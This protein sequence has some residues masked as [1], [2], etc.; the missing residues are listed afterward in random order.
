MTSGSD[1]YVETDTVRPRQRSIIGTEIVAFWRNPMR[2]LS[3]LLSF[4]LLALPAP[5]LAQTTEPVAPS[6]ADGALAAATS[7]AWIW[8]TLVALAIVGG[9][10]WWFVS[11][12]RT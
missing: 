2:D 9:I 1:R 4:V 6:A 10:A 11:R 7:S 12:R 8:W 3:S 5:A